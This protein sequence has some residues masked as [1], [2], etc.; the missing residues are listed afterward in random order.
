M[1][2]NSFNG[3]IRLSFYNLNF[4]NKSSEYLPI[5]NYELKKDKLKSGIYMSYRAGYFLNFFSTVQRREYFGIRQFVCK[6]IGEEYCIYFNGSA[7]I[8]DIEKSFCVSK[9]E[10]FIFIKEVLFS[11]CCKKHLF[12]FKYEQKDLNYLSNYHKDNFIL[13]IDENFNKRH[14]FYKL[15]NRRLVTPLKDYANTDTKVA[16]LLKYLQPTPFKSKFTPSITANKKVL[17][18]FLETVFK[19]KKDK[20]ETNIHTITCKEPTKET[21]EVW[22]EI[23]GGV[24]DLSDTTIT[25]SDLSLA[26]LTDLADEDADEWIDRM[27]RENA[28]T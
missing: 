27:M 14:I 18:T 1:L 10:Y 23:G 16:N 4:C 12:N 22:R 7:F 24:Q 13:F 20:V 5:M 9:H 19:E 28:N 17:D 2:Y 21:I 6:K 15:L 3:S 11:L 8:I 26:D 25:N